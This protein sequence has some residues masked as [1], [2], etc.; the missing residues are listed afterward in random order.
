MAKVALCIIATNGYIDF[1][2]PLL[3]SADKY[4]LQGHDVEYHVFTNKQDYCFET[5]CVDKWRWGRLIN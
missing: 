2:D 1:V 4:F 5:F 3:V